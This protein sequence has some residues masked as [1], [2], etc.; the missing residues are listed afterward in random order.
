[1]IEI[2]NSRTSIII[3]CPR[4]ALYQYRVYIGKNEI[5][6]SPQSSYWYI[7]ENKV[8]SETGSGS[9]MSSLKM[10]VEIFGYTPETRTSTFARGTDLPYINGCSTKQLINPVRPGDPTFQ[11]LFMP[12]YTAE[13]A[14]HIHATTRVVYVAS[15]SG[16]SIVGSAEYSK[17]YDLKE[18]DVVILNKMTPHHF[19]TKE[20]SLLVLPIHVYSSVASEEHNHPMFVGT[21]KI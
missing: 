19:E 12:P 9:T 4:Q 20:N 3:D 6:T 1:L 21:H 16:K 8:V 10:C 13:Q 18:G 11:M 17:V 14:H 5:Q 15:G 2:L 7:D